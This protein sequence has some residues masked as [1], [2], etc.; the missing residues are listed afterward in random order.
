MFI[1]C[2]FIVKPVIYRLITEN[3]VFFNYCQR[4]DSSTAF[5]MSQIYRDLNIYPHTPR[6]IGKAQRRAI[7]LAKT[8]IFFTTPHFKAD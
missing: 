5:R 7:L 4:Y 1:M 3:T 2:L 8:A 6:A